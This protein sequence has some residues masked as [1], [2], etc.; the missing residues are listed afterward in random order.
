MSLNSRSVSAPKSRSLVLLLHCPLRLHLAADLT[1]FVYNL[2]GRIHYHEQY[3]DPE[4]RHYYTRLAWGLDGPS[5]TEGEMAAR[6]DE[7]VGH[8]AETEWSLHDENEPLRM[9]IFVSKEP[10]CLYDL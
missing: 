3:V 10:W 1:S 8:E 4:L 7:L 9:A 6:L 2:G 5:E